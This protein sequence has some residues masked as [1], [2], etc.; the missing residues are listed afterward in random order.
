MAK[1][2]ITIKAAVQEHVSGETAYSSSWRE[3]AELDVTVLLD[4]GFDRDEVNGLVSSIVHR[5]HV[6]FAPQASDRGV[7]IDGDPIPGLTSDS[8]A[9]R[10]DEIGAPI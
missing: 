3:L 4:E 7:Y 8:V 9:E 2:R 6:A 1:R 5:L 10:P